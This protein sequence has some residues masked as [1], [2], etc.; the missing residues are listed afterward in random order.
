MVTVLGYACYI[1]AILFVCFND[2]YILEEREDNRFIER[3]MTIQESL[4][5]YTLPVILLFFLGYFLKNF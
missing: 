4:F 2:V 5:L 3:Q 1:I